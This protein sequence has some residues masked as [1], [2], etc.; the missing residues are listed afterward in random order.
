MSPD[1]GGGV[2]A[3]SRSGLGAQINFED[4][5]P[6]F[7]YGREENNIRNKEGLIYGRKEERKK[8]NK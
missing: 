4:S 2:I 1:G 7:T 6:F 5:T 8:V 3:G